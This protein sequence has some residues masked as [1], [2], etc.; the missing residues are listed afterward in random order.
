MQSGVILRL[1]LGHKWSDAKRYWKCCG[2]HVAL[3]CVNRIIGREL[4]N[5]GHGESIKREVFAFSML[6]YLLL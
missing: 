1:V 2:I 5:C 6:L 4:K 3:N